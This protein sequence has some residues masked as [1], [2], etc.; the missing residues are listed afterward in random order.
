MVDLPGVPPSEDEKLQQLLRKYLEAKED[1][2]SQLVEDED[3]V[4]TIVPVLTA[5]RDGTPMYKGAKQI[6]LSQIPIVAGEF[7]REEGDQILEF[8]K[9]EYGEELP[10][11][12]LRR[13][14]IDAFGRDG[15][16][17]H[18]WRHKIPDIEKKLFA[19]INGYSRHR[20][21]SV[22]RGI[23]C[24]E[25]D[26]SLAEGIQLLHPKEG[27][28]YVK[29]LKPQSDILRNPILHNSGILEI[30][31]TQN[32][33]QKYVSKRSEAQ[34]QLALT[35]LRLYTSNS[36]NVVVNHRVPETYKPSGVVSGI[37]RSAL[38]GSGYSV[39]SEDEERLKNLFALLSEFFNEDQ[40]SF[41]IPIDV[42]LDHFETSVSHQTSDHS[43]IT[44]GIIGIE[45]LYKHYTKGS[46]SG[47]DL[48]RYASYT[49]G[50]AVRH[51]DPMTIKEDLEKA[52]D[53]RNNVV[54][55]DSL[56]DSSD[57]TLQH[58]VWNLLRYSII[59]FAELWN[60]NG[61][62]FNLPIECALID[63]EERSEFTSRLEHIDLKEYLPVNDSE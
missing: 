39:S 43:S 16:D 42:A 12:C 61:D 30:K 49:L 10:S 31:T 14:Y 9:E 48:R 5:A 17:I 20:T 11:A 33:H 7:P 45:S 21:I 52:Y 51:V 53:T 54:H 41:D 60:N 32:K 50:T 4:K 18:N 63:E 3:T 59:I 28:T 2:L 44:F 26:I 15:G 47:S 56:P 38:L 46:K 55:G 29:G 34:L 1:E 19:D 62:Y 22:V 13:V 8:V 37:D 27:E 40:R 35:T 23:E 58:R 24:S 6:D 25:A 36:I 57:K